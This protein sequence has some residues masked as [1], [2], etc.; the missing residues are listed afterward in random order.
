MS[1]SRPFA[2]RFITARGVLVL[3]AC[4]VCCSTK[5]QLVGT[6]SNDALSKSI[7]GGQ[8]SAWAETWVFRSDNTC[9]VSEGTRGGQ[10][11]YTVLDDGSIKIE[12]QGGAT[13]TARLENNK[14]VINWGK[15]QSVLFKF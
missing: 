12:I 2:S 6:W 3:V 14:L 8:P 9:R 7:A 4:F 1:E 15:V 11:K 10:C 5:S 13:V